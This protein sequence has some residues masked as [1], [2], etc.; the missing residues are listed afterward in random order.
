MAN[1]ETDDAKRPDSA[2]TKFRKSLAELVDTLSKCRPSYVRCIKPNERK[3]ALTAD[4]ERF[5]HQIR[6]LGLLENIR[7]RRAGFCNRQTYEDFLQRYKMTVPRGKGST[8]PQWKASAKEGCLVI[9][10]HFQWKPEMYRLGKTKIFIRKPKELFQLENARQAALPMVATM[11]QTGYRGHLARAYWKQ[12]KAVLTL[13]GRFRGYKKRHAY[14]QTKGMVVIVAALR[15][16]WEKLR[17]AKT[18]SIMKAQ[19]IL[20]EREAKKQ[21]ANL[22]M[23]VLIQSNCRAAVLSACFL[24]CCWAVVNQIC[25]N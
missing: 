6:Y 9:V 10:K 23:I 3:A 14:H 12:M 7:V 8:W 19:A 25:S 1:A 4:E 11:I 18:K 20:H 22:K 2:G 13:Q 15:A 16:K 24:T 21:Y 5:R 17:Y